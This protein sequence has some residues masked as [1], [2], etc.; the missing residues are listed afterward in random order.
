MRRAVWALLLALA[1]TAGRADTQAAAP[2][3]AAAHFAEP[4]TRYDHGVLGDAVEWGALV[5]DLTG[6]PDCAQTGR[7][8]ETLRLPETRVFED[9]A[10]RLIA[11]EGG[12]VLAMVVETDL[13]RGA[14]LSLYGAGGLVAATPFLGRPHRWLAP[15]GAA[16]LDGDGHV[17]VAYV[18]TPHLGKTL[19]IWRLAG[20][21]LTEV[22]HRAGVTA[23]QIG[24]DYILG[25]VRN[26]AA[27]PDIL[28]ASSDWSRL[29]V[30]HLDGRALTATDLGP[31]SRTA[32]AAPLACRL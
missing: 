31:W 18:E 5:L 30:F 19:R 17:E 11:G 6:C 16:D 28:A 2:T 27:G 9:L 8:R 32:Y 10:P 1:A 29:L 3:I 12:Q 14:R 15:L 24:W 21:R 25:A 23:H 13:A 7:Y 22:A 26:C 4:T 20:G